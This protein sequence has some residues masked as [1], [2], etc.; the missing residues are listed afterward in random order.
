MDRRKRAIALV[1]AA[2]ALWGSSFVVI[3]LATDSGA[4]PVTLAFLRFVVAAAAS[5]VVVRASGPVKLAGFKDPLV[6]GIGL[7]NTAGFVFQYVGIAG[8]NSAAAALLANIGVVVVAVLSSF[9]L[10]EK[11]SARTAVAVILTFAGASLLATRGEA[12]SFQ[13]SEFQAAVL[14]GIGSVI[15]SVFVVM[16]KVALQRGKHTESDLSFVTLVITAIAMLPLTLALEGVPTFAYAAVAWG[17][18]LYTGI[19]CS[20]VAYV[21]YMVGLK[22]LPATSTAVL[23]VAEVLVAFGLTAAVFGTVLTGVA[24]VGA[25]LVLGGIAL[26]SR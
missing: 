8:T 7:M 9:Y 10:N 23:T 4:P 12:S 21:I 25:G 3:K 15:W 6:L 17:A 14:I 19:L 18:I 1:L 5:L 22:E 11:I 24:A 16:N 2:A 26:A 20:S 13:T